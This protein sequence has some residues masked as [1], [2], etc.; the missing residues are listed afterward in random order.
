MIITLIELM[1]C[2]RFYRM[3][4]LDFYDS[5]VCMWFKTSLDML[6]IQTVFGTSHPTEMS[7][8]GML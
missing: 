1:K 6:K 4:T 3:T 8:P 5:Q 7:Q 2:R